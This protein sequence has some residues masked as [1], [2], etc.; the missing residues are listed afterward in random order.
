[1]LSG[2]KLF[3]KGDFRH[4]RCFTCRMVFKH[5][6]L[7]GTHYNPYKNSTTVFHMYRDYN[8]ALSILWQHYIAILMIYFQSLAAIVL[9]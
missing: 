3:C 2:L 4:V 8:Y 9:L 7:G 1:M 6:I 5:G